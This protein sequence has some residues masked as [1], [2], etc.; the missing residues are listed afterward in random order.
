MVRQLEQ[1][2]KVVRTPDKWFRGLKDGVWGLVRLTGPLGRTLNAM[3]G[4]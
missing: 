4:V 2:L 3:L 1:R